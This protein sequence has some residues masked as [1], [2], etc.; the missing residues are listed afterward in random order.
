MTI[1][2]QQSRKPLHQGYLNVYKYTLEVPSQADSEISVVLENRELVHSKDSVLVLIYVPKLDSFVLC[3]EFRMG[4]FFNKNQDDPFILECVSGAIEAHDT[5]EETAIKESYE[6]T[7]LQLDNVML[8]A[9]AYKTP[10]LMTEKVYIYYAEYAGQPTEGSYGLK[11]EGE[12]ILTQV[13]PRE[14]I[15]ALMDAMVIQDA[16]TLVALNWFRATNKTIPN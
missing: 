3:K 10:G 6:E 8:I 14:Q 7:G 12:D 5:P 16:A 13:L 1:I 4:V 2:K 11:A 9:Q 15:Y